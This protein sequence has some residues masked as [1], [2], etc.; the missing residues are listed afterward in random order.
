MTIWV[1]LVTSACHPT[2]PEPERPPPPARPAA[3]PLTGRLVDAAGAPVA[4]A[5]VLACSAG[6]CQDAV[7]RSDGRFTF[8]LKRPVTVA[9]KA[10]GVVAGPGRRAAALWPGVA[11]GHAPVEVGDLI[12]PDLPPPVRLP[13]RGEPARAL[14]LGDGLTVT[15]DRDA[16]RAPV[17]TFL[18]EGAARRLGPDRHPSFTEALG[19]VVDAVYVVEPFGTTSA[20]PIPVSA[21]SDLPE[22][23]RVHFRTFSAVDGAPSA[24]VP[25]RVEAGRARTDPG[26]GIGEL[27]YLVIAEAP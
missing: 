11:A 5:R 1:L 23:R 19:E 22:G 25:G 16:L 7:T 3:T 24:P 21:P 13:A 15:L 4:D 6:Y 10:D 9:L 18:Y 2:S 8:A 14:T 27:G 17:H 26:Q 20:A 12:A